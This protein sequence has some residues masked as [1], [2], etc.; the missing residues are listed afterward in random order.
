MYLRMQSVD[1]GSSAVEDVGDTSAGVATDVLITLV[2]AAVNCSVV[3]AYVP[4]A[5]TVSSELP[6]IRNDSCARICR[7]LVSIARNMTANGAK[8][9][10]RKAVPGVHL[11]PMH[12]ASRQAVPGIHSNPMHRASRIIAD[13]ADRNGH[14]R[15]PVRSARR[16]RRRNM[17]G[18]SM[19]AQSTSS[20]GPPVQPDGMRLLASSSP[21]IG[22][23][24][25]VPQASQHRRKST[26]V[27]SSNPMLDAE[28]QVAPAPSSTQGASV[29]MPRARGPRG[30]HQRR[31]TRSRG[32]GRRR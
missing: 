5:D 25:F 23:A 17:M 14:S 20:Q 10:K 27:L 15:A 24:S 1:Q 26:F 31:P 19:E 29:A 28:R 21:S 9:G 8:A 2:L 11:N 6:L 7:Y 18:G 12:R 16:G 13:G 3:L 30:R 32:L 4:I 22:R